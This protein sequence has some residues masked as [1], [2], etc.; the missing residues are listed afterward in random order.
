MGAVCVGLA[1]LGGCVFMP[2]QA[3]LRQLR[4]WWS[5]PDRRAGQT[6]ETRHSAAAPSQELIGETQVLFSHYED[7]FS[8]IGRQYNP[9]RYSARRTRR[10][11]N[12]CRARRRLSSC[13]RRRSSP[14]R[15]GYHQYS[16]D[17]ALLFTTEK[18]ARPAGSRT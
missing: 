15:R 7:T 3:A 11:T 1:L 8:A 6:A 14:R 9:P 4:W 16:R 18:S 17:A 12:G 5:T 10:S 2:A 13:R